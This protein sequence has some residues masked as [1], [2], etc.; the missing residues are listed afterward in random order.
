MPLFAALR[1]VE[2]NRVATA[3]SALLLVAISWLG[4]D[5]WQLHRLMRQ[6]ASP[7]IQP[8]VQ[9]ASAR[10]TA[11]LTRHVRQVGTNYRTLFPEVLENPL[12]SESS[13]K[14]LVSNNLQWLEQVAPLVQERPQIAVELGRTYLTMAQS[15]WSN[16]HVSMKDPGAAQLLLQKAEEA[17]RHI[18]ISNPNMPELQQL[19]QE[20]EKEEILLRNSQ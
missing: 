20:I 10:G 12:A 14:E 1:L 11:E 7:A 2:R 6:M 13:K 5:E 19:A 17:L 18:D 3:V 15:E 4:W 8:S 9:I 16:D